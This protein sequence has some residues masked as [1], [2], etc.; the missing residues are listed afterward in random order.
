MNK[1]ICLLLAAC[2]VFAL[3]ACGVAQQANPW[4][5]IT[6]AEAGELC[7][8]ALAPP[9]GAENE[10][11]SVLDS[12]ADA[13]GTPGPLVQLCFELDGNRFTAR[14]QL[15]GDPD[16]DI[17]GM[18]YDWIDRRDESLK[19]WG[20]LPCRSFRW[21]G[22]KE[23]ADLCAWYD[24]DS[25]ISYSLSVTAGDLDGFD[26]LAVAEALRGEG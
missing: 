5:E 8:G 18:Y 22:E 19:N 9:E 14:E 7:G 21:I 10:Q 13:S 1:I 17:S 24:A 12:A 20:E 23:Y 25:G 6:R 4:R 15:T 16:A 2:L 3:A 11:W 26:L